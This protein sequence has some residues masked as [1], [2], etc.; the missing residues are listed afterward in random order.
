MYARQNSVVYWQLSDN[1][2]DDSEVA[3]DIRTVKKKIKES[4]VPIWDRLGNSGR[5]QKPHKQHHNPKANVVI[6]GNG[7]K[8]I[9][10]PPQ[11]KYLNPVELLFN[12]MTN[13]YIR[14]QFRKMVKII[15]DEN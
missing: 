5:K 1:N 2:V 10:L 14:P 7:G 15:V 11:C 12:D 8:V 3:R 4:D 13:H 9:Q 6:E